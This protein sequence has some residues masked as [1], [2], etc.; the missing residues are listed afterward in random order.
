MEQLSK[1]IG[2]MDKLA[3][4]TDACKGLEAAV[5]QVWPH[6]EKIEY[7]RHLMENMKKYYSGDIY[8]KN[9]WPAVR[10]YTPHKFKEKTMVL[11]AKRRKISTALTGGTLPAVIHQLNEASKGLC[12]LKVTK[13]HLEE[14]EVTEIY[15]DEEVRRHVM[16]LTKHICTYREWQGFKLL[17]PL[18]K[19]KK[20]PGRLKK[21][22]KRTKKTAPRSGRKKAKKDQP[23]T[24]QG[25]PRTRAAVAREAAAKAAREV[26]ETADKATTIAEAPE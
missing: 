20:P 4:C 2:P 1:A 10:A 9:M 19:K 8:A 21:S 23:P 25:T 6:C 24:D 7:F 5:S 15:K 3:V 12:H 18:S 26:V 11:F 16:Y 17:P 13:G 22:R 14:A